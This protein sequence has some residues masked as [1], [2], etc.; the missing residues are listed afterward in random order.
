MAVAGSINI[1]SGLSPIVDSETRIL[2]LGSLPSD[3]SIRLQQYY[4]YTKN[5]FWTIIY[6][7]FGDG[8]PFESYRILI[9]KKGVILEQ[10]SICQTG[11]E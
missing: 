7:I 10:S 9:C 4:A 6:S 2:I 11:H 5:H 3:E 1:K 8:K